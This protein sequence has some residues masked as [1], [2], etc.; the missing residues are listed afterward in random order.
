[1][2]QTRE[3]EV[4]RY[5]ALKI[6]VHTPKEH[7]WSVRH[8]NAAPGLHHIAVAVVARTGFFFVPVC[9]SEEGG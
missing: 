5:E 1:M 3:K 2:L 6:P 8:V 7:S 4:P 9:V